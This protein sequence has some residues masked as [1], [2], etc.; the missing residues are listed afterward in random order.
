MIGIS[1]NKYNFTGGSGVTHRLPWKQKALKLANFLLN[2][3][4]YFCR[5]FALTGLRIW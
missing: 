5:Y 3:T 1:K 4:I 2:L